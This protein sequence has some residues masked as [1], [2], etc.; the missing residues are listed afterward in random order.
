MEGFQEERDGSDESDDGDLQD[1]DIQT[2]LLLVSM[3]QRWAHITRNSADAACHFRRM[4]MS[5]RIQRTW[6]A[7]VVR[8]TTRQE[9][10]PAP[11][12]A[13]A[14]E[15][16][17]DPEPCSTCGRILCRHGERC[18]RRNGRC[19]F[20]HC[21]VKAV[22]PT[23][24]RH[25]RSSATRRDK[26]A[27]RTY[28]S[29]EERTDSSSGSNAG[30]CALHRA[31]FAGNEPRARLLL[32]RGADV[33]WPDPRAME[34][35]PLHCAAASG[36]TAVVSTLLYHRADASRMQLDGQIPLHVAHQYGHHYVA[37]LLQQH[38]EQSGC[39]PQLP[40]RL[41]TQPRRLL[42]RE[43]VIRRSCTRHWLPHLP[44]TG[45]QVAVPKAPFSV[46]E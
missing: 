22:A 42:K 28:R 37:A 38:M 27:S 35:T 24:P 40:W 33:N 43:A 19:N 8:C 21:T 5:R 29:S 14:T 13:H 25:N 18:N 1:L 26:F 30:P 7:H 20:C 44:E 39:W 9:V 3:L 36:H 17:K 45:G 15:A 11:S 6:R 41:S 23:P 34:A 46:E 12:A 10:V 4:F 31:A 32:E 16:Q 2:S